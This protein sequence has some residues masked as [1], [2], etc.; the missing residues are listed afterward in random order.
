[1]LLCLW[2]YHP[3]YRGLLLLD[4][5]LGKYIDLAYEK[6]FPVAGKALKA[7]GI[8]PKVTPTPQD[9]KTD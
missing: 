7:V 6:I 2:C 3:T 5:K 1:M 9:K 4:S 8:E